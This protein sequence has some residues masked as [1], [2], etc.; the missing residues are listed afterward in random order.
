MSW[1]TEAKG[2]SSKARNS[3]KSLAESG[4]SEYAGVA[5]ILNTIAQNGREYARD[6]FLAGCANQIIEAAQGFLNDIGRKPKEQGR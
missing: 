6:E 4:Q 1:F 3:L 2:L 5:D